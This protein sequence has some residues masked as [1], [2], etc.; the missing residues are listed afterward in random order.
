[1][2]STYRRR[3]ST[4]CAVVV[5]IGLTVGACGEDEREK[6]AEGCATIQQTVMKQQEEMQQTLNNALL[7][8][9]DAAAGIQQYKEM[10]RRQAGEIR[11]SAQQTGNDKI[12]R[13]AEDYARQQESLADNPS[14]D[15]QKI[16]T[17]V[18]NLM[19]TVLQECRY[20]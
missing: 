19:N 16:A 17:T 7:G 1:M 14:P 4:I 9:V 6:Q 15:L 11:E 18:G 20:T 5:M 10:F 13:A 2:R 8:Q 3:H 12:I